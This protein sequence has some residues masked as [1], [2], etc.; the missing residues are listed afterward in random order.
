MNKR[1][2]A[3][4]DLIADCYYRRKELTNIAGGGSRFNVMANMAYLGYNCAIIG[5]CGNDEIGNILINDLKNI[6]VDTEHI[7]QG[8][9][10][11]R[12]FNLSLVEEKLPN[13][14]YICSKTS[15]IDNHPTWYENTEED[16]DYIRKQIDPE[17]VIILDEV[18][19]F[20]RLIINNLDN[21]LI[22]DIGNINHLKNLDN[23][24]ILKLKKKLEIVQL[25]ERVATYLIERFKFKSI[26]DI[27]NL[28]S[29]KLLVITYGNK[30]A[31]F[32]YPNGTIVKELKEAEKEVDPTGAGDAFLSSLTGYYYDY[33]KE[34][35]DAFIEGA[36]NNAT[37]LTREVVKYQGA[38]GHII[39]NLS[40]K[41]IKKKEL[42]KD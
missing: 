13:V 15:P 35:S 3:L 37:S 21:D 25:N 27:Y 14:S 38:R 6:G 24:E 32:I 1:Y 39:N 10:K 30:G 16:F 11:T 41:N 26:E 5:G 22:I 7:Y 23:K 40:K 20:S 12:A 2:V 36:F 34:L 17:D 28:L 19:S 29:P 4:G 31:I 8:N 42:K 33:D 9:K 18:D